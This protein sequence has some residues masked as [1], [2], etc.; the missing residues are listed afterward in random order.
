MQQPPSNQ[1]KCTTTLEAKLTILGSPIRCV[2]KSFLR[3]SCI[4]EIREVGVA[5]I[6]H[7]AAGTTFRQKPSTNLGLAVR[8]SSRSPQLDLIATYGIRLNESRIY[9]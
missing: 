5:A 9:D 7:P 1:Q 2:A 8:H 3:G 4:A 6:A